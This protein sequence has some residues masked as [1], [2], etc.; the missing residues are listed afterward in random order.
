ML[1][2]LDEHLDAVII[3]HGRMTTEAMKAKVMLKKQG[4]QVGIL[5]L[6]QIKPY[7]K[8]AREV[9][10][11]LPAHACHVL[12][13]EE[14]IRTG[15]MGMNLSAALAILDVMQNK[16]VSIKALEDHFAIQTEN[17][18]IWKSFGLDAESIARDILR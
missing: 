15:G 7:E 9:A 12:F 16:T 8:I 1:W 17:E 6:E 10:N 11:L 3:T 5:L 2:F 4:K 14:E 13:L 18:P